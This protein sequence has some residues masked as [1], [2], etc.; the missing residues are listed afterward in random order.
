M[1][2][3]SPKQP[4]KRQ[5]SPATLTEQDDPTKSVSFTF[6]PEKIKIGHSSDTNAVKRA[7]GL[8]AKKLEPGRQV[9]VTSEDPVTVEPGDTTLSFSEILLDGDQVMDDT[10]T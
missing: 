6:A 5:S 1:A 3:Q 8:P 10:Q 4:A 9:V 2:A 7:R